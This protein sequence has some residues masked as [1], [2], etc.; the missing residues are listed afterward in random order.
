MVMVTATV[1]YCLSGSQYILQPTI[2]D[3]GAGCNGVMAMR[4]CRRRERREEEEKEEEEEKGGGIQLPLHTC[5]PSIFFF[6]LLSNELC[7]YIQYS[8]YIIVLV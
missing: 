6:F 2:G 5:G 8:T 4:K 7:A 1:I 3:L